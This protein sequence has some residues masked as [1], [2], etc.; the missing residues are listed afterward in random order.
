L[1]NLI[2]RIDKA[3]D[4]LES[5]GDLIFTGFLHRRNSKTG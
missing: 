3:S 5:N 2:W 1:G 4:K